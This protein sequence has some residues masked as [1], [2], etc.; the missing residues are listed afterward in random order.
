MFNDSPPHTIMH[1][2]VSL[3]REVDAIQIPSGD[4]ITL[5]TGTPVVITQT[6][7]GT[8]TVATSAG[9]ARI[10]SSDADALGVD[11]D[12]KQEKQA[13][14]DRLADATLEEQVWHQMKQVFDPE[15]PVDIV[16][17]GLVYDCSLSEVDSG[18]DVDVKM[19]LTAPGCGMG[20]VIAA[21]AQARIMSL[22]EIN[23]AR[24]ELVWDP[25][26]NQDMISEEGKMKLGMM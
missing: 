4:T 22:S 9:L 24:V 10:S 14:A 1:E 8:Y 21:D 11:P 13:E 15:I 23:D 3:T 6:L 26:W 2:E 12:Q 5:P 19:T 17:L 18:T 16:N 20:P 25:P 7:G